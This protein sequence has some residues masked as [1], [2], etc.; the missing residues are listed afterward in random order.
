MLLHEEFENTSQTSSGSVPALRMAD[1]TYELPEQAIAQLP[2]AERDASR[3][4]VCDH[5]QGAWADTHMR[6][7]PTVLAKV[8]NSVCLVVNDTRVVP[9]RLFLRKPTGGAV[10]VLLN[11]PVT[12]T[13][14]PQ[15]AL[16]LTDASIW[17][18]MIGGRNVH[19]GMMLR[20]SGGTLDVEVLNRHGMEATIRITP[21]NGNTLASALEAIGHVPLPPYIDR[22]DTVQDRERY[23]SVFAA[24]NGSV[25][26]PTASLHFTPHLMERMQAIGVETARVTLHVGMGTF[27]PVDVADAR[28]HA[29]HRERIEISITDVERIADAVS[30]KAPYVLPVGTTAMRTLESL[31]WLG[32][33]HLKG[34]ASLNSEPRVVPQ[35]VAYDHMLA[36]VDVPSAWWTIHDWMQGSGSQ[37]LV[38]ETAL[39]LAPG[40]RIRVASGLITNFHQPGSTLLLLVATLLGPRWKEVYAQ[41][42]SSGYRFLSYGDAMFITRTHAGDTART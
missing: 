2:L 42:I 25:A 27:R 19:A 35:F 26:A 11:E 24:H 1:F 28:S 15:V 33:M 8:S 36:S 17:H 7:L 9:A 30:G 20:D 39:M 34:I 40:A 10:E 23:Q 3:L 37:R 5:E 13:A 29:M 22:E 41:A 4:L 38:A 16:A 6:N 21:R 12:P 32:A 14:D 18:A 31:Y